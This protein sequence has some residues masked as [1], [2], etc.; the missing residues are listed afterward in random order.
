MLEED[1]KL[2]QALARVRTSNNHSNNNRAD[3]AEEQTSAET[4]GSIK[5][6][7]SMV[8]EKVQGFRRVLL[9]PITFMHITLG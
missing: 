9:I 2:A 8:L 5:T 3:A 7:A 6:H 1:L 4:E